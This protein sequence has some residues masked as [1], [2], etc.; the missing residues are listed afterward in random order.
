MNI[1]REDRDSIKSGRESVAFTP[2]EKARI[3]EASQAK[4]IT[5]STY[6]RLA[7]LEKLKRDKF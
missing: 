1:A 7:V 3:K 5:K 6:I 2:S 4:Y